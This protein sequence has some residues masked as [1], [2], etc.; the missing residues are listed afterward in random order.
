LVQ[1]SHLHTINKRL[2]AHPLHHPALG[3]N[4]EAAL[5][6]ILADNLQLAA[7]DLGGPVDQTAGKALV[8]P[9]LPDPGVVEPGPQQRPLRAV[10]VLDACRDDV[11]SQEQTEGVGDGEPLAALDLLTRI[12]APGGGGTVSAVRTD[13]ESIRPA[14]GSASRPS[15][16]RTLLR[17]ASWIRSTAPSS[18]HHVK[19]QY[20]VGH[21]AKSFGSCRQAHPVRTT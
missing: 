14:L 13:W 7:E 21:G 16:S 19:Y 9:D 15:A 10:A 3:L 12:E 17:R 18:C 20:T 11:D 6:G 1:V 5:V 4:L 2:T 8:C